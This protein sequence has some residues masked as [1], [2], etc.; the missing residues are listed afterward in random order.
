MLKFQGS[1]KITFVTNSMKIITFGPQHWM[2]KFPRYLSTNHFLVSCELCVCVHRFLR[3]LVFLVVLLQ[4]VSSL[5]RKKSESSFHRFLFFIFLGKLS[6]KLC[7]HIT[8]CIFLT[9]FH[10]AHTSSPHACIRTARL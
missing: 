7:T 8:T 5:L 9:I 6:G 4:F 10:P 3:Y 2:L 1:K